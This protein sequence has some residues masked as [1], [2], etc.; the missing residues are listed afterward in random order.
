MFSGVRFRQV[1]AAVKVY[2]VVMPYPLFRVPTFYITDP[3]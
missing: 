3:N 2:Y 1:L